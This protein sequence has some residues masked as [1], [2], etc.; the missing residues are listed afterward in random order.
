MVYRLLAA[1]L[2]SFAIS[3]HAVTFS[4]TQ[5]NV[6]AVALSDAA[7]DFQSASSPT[8]LVTA[9]AASVA[10]NNAAT[11][12]AIAGP[13]LFTT[14][15]DA[16][17]T[18]GI[19]SAV[20]TAHFLGS[21]VNAAHMLL[22]LD[23]LR[24]DVLSGTGGGSTT[25]FVTLKSGATTIF[26]DFITGSRAFDY[27]ASVGSTSTLELTLSSDASAGFLGTGP[28]NSSSFGLVEITAPVPE[29]ETYLLF[30]IGLAAIG[31]ARRRKA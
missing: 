5:F 6:D 12:G 2:A 18:G 31:A 22:G 15:A 7:P 17:A 25:L 20:S 11:A 1:F 19:A 9:S 29:P 16:S 23:F 13:F 26:D 14:S 3:A 4:S 8:A 21:F 30:A 27:L 10:N 24:T 28:G